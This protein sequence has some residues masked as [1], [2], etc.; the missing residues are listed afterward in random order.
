MFALVVAHN[1]HL[2]GRCQILG[3]QYF[4]VCSRRQ[5]SGSACRSLHGGWVKWQMGVEDDG[6]D[7]LAKQVAPAAEDDEASWP[8]MRII[9]LVVSL[10]VS[11]WTAWADA[12]GYHV[13]KKYS[14]TLE[15][16]TAF[17]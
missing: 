7:S 1:V 15:I 8:D 17:D 4:L 16:S 13:T 5:G 6:S 3:L 11:V 12:R 2:I 9:I 10:V 14:E